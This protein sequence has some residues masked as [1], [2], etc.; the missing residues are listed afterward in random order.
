MDKDL[1]LQCLMEGTRAYFVL[2]ERKEK[3]KKASGRK[4][5]VHCI[6]V[7]FILAGLKGKTSIFSC[8]F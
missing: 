7:G 3:K 1:L 5:S 8:A 4:P 6:P 2:K